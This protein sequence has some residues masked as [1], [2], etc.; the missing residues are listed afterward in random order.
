MTRL[1][2]AL[3]PDWTTRAWGAIFIVFLTGAL[4]L[5]LAKLVEVVL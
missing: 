4:V 5:S 3:G 2:E 1:L